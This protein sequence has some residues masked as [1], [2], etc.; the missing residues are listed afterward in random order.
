MRHIQEKAK[1]G[2]YVGCKE[3]NVSLWA[4][5]TRVEIR[6]VRYIPDCNQQLE[7]RRPEMCLDCMQV[8]DEAREEPEEGLL[9][10]RRSLLLVEI[11]QNE[12]ENR[13]NFGQVVNLR[14]IVI[15][16]R[17]IAMILYNVHDEP[18]HRI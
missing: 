8:I 2:K 14:L 15:D 3:L 12:Y 13:E 7:V 17:S 16:P 18:G 5:Q 6:D 4:G 9:L 1:P 11:G 10:E